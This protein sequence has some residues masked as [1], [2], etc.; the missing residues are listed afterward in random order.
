MEIYLIRHTTPDIETGICYGQAD[1][2]IATSFIRE[3]ESIA[4]C[5]PRN[6]QYVFSS[7][8]QRC[9]KLTDVLFPD[10]STEF[11]DS[12]KEIDCGDWELKKW[13]DLPK[14]IL[15]SW[16]KEFVSSPFPNGESYRQFY[17][18]VINQFEMIVQRCNGPV[19]IVSHGGVMRSILSCI[20]D[21][22]LQDSF[23]RFKISYGAVIKITRTGADWRY[24]V[25]SGKPF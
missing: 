13:D 12:L 24:D 6:I 22:P 17:Q 2:D 23:D 21:T 5:L 15:D 9:R 10:H 16:M 25:L 14:D 1:L 7:P 19:A 20:T 8:L 18:R 4:K 3:T 11:N